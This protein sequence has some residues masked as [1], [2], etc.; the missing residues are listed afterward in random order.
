M[1]KKQAKPQPPGANPT[2]S[3]RPKARAKGPKAAE[4]SARPPAACGAPPG[5]AMEE[6]FGRLKAQ[7]GLAKAAANGRALSKSQRKKKAKSKIGKAPP[8]DSFLD[9]LTRPGGGLARRNF[10]PD[11]LPI[12]TEAE[13]GIGQGGGTS[14]CPFDCACCF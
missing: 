2:P 12:Y 5:C 7:Q 3:K 1:A 6:L 14:D 9:Q 13:L 4:A 11:G 8:K 10:T